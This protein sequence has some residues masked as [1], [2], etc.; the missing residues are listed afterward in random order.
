M[1]RSEFRHWFE[2]PVRW[3]DMD[4]LGHVNNIQFLRYLESG[5][6]NYVEEAVGLTLSTEI[7]EGFILADLQCAFLQ[8]L[9]YP[10]TL[11]VGTRVSGMGNSSFQLR[12]AIFRKGEEA[13]AATSRGV[14]VWF[15][16]LKQRSKTIPEAVRSAVASYELIPT[17]VDGPAIGAH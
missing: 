7:R 14:M 6:I 4:A 8:Q 15:D 3:G 9:N 12:A 5:R 17:Q 16:F 10:L 1:Q 2:L 13:P 11:D